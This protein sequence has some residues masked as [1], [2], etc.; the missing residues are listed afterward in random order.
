VSIKTLLF[1]LFLYV[2]L[3]WLLALLWHP[4]PDLTPFG[5]RWTI[6]GLIAVLAFVI[7]ARIFGWWRLWRARSA[8]RAPVPT[9]PAVAVHEDDAALAALIAEAAAALAKAPGY[10]EKRGQSPLAGMPLYLLIGPE[11][12]GKT[13][14][15]I[16]SGLE[17]QLLAGRLTG[18]AEV[19]PTRLCNIWFAKDAVF[20]EISGRAFR[21]DVGRWTGVLKVLL[22]KQLRPLWRQLWGEPEQGFILRGVVGF[23]EAKSLT[24]APN[25]QALEHHSRDWQER[26]R[27]VGEVFGVDFPVYQVIT[28]CDGIRYFPEFFR[29]LPEPETK[30]VLGCTLALTETDEA[31]RREVFVE[32]AAKQLTRS[33]RPLYEE[34]AKRRIKHLAHEPDPARRPA[35]YEFPYQFRKQIRSPL[36]QFLS[37]VFR[38]HPLQPGPILRG[39]YFTGV[40]EVEKAPA[41]LGESR[42]DWSGPKAGMEA[43]RLFSPEDASRIFRSETINPSASARGGFT[44]RWIFASNLFHDV[45]TADRRAGEPVPVDPRLER[46]RRAVLTA[47]CAL[48]AMLCVAFSWSWAGN[49]ELLQ[50]LGQIDKGAQKQGDMRVELRSLEAQR[51]GIVRLQSGAPLRMHWGLYSGDAVLPGLRAAYFRRFQQL[52]LNPVNRVMVADLQ[53]L[54]ATPSANEPYD[55]VYRLLKAHLMISSG[56]C[57]TDPA[58]LS[59]ALKDVRTRA[60]LT[61]GSDE[62]ALADAQI[63]FYAN[64]L[65]RENPCFLKEDSEARDRARQ[66]LRQLKGVDWIYH[67]ILANA[68]KSLSKPRRLADLAANYPDVLRG[69][70]EVSAVFTRD[71]WNYV[72]KASKEFN[73]TSLGETCVMGDTAGVVGELKQDAEV[74][75]GIQRLFVREYIYKWRDFVAGFSVAPYNSSDDAARKL[76]ILADH[77]SPLLALFFM[78][79]TQTYFAPPASQPGGWEQLIPG[80]DKLRT[81][82]KKAEKAAGNVAG[83]LNAGDQMSSPADIIR[84]FQPVHWVV[85]PG[86]EIWVNE[87]NGAY[88][89]SLDQLRH[90]MQEIAR[91]G[92][93]PTVH[94]AAKQ[95]Y[96][97]ALEAVTQITRGFKPVGVEGLDVAVQRLLEEPIRLTKGFIITDMD[98]A[99]AGRVNG[100][101]QTFCAGLKNVLR[102]YPFHPSGED[103]SLEELAG[104]FAPATGKIWKFQAQTLGEFAVKDGS[105]WKP[106][107]SAKKPQVTQD[108]LNF[109]NRAQAITDAFY[110]SGATPLQLTYTLRPKL[111]ASFGNSILELEVDGRPYAWTSSLQKQ[112]TWPPPQGTKDLGAKAFIRT[113]PVAYPFASRAGL[114]AIFRIMGDAEPR[115][116]PSRLVE[117]KYGRGGEGLREPIQPAP[118]RLEIVNFPGGVDMFNPKFFEGL[119][120]PPKAVE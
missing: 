116:F 65:P 115:P 105:Q 8:A 2:S 86:S 11:A 90:S 49:H 100:D 24:G 76:G 67:K 56:G 34:I 82:G 89:D 93:D 118:V 70:A 103:L 72:E 75:Q 94:Q 106:K 10:A 69:H 113:G 16:N 21:G 60:V 13:S 18:T 35:V 58:F 1:T 62:H 117:W 91:A 107:D 3:V 54:P 39:Y 14:T 101:L 104:W 96:D 74:A 98:K 38:S 92:A 61:G 37:D 15:F 27:A 110:P 80:V 19:V 23:I 109:L 87:K 102:K 57:T 78:T 50:D 111:D 48:C 55:R 7:G 119:H 25:L 63:D 6:V 12:S 53:A 40:R 22:G 43:T 88:I 41:D 112:F 30:Q 79:A 84:S 45:I 31:H 108:M 99:T 120:C 64:E 17:P 71:G 44:L 73:A 114:W 20:I 42:A 26:L 81:A 51:V 52:L 9:K 46:Y 66:Y 28:K 95:N 97:K 5:L 68:E 77:K 4:G 47:V 33:F 32:D 59:Q 36:V 85:P 29:R 83:A